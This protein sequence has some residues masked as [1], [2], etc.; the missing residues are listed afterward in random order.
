MRLKNHCRLLDFWV[1][2]ISNVFALS[3]LSLSPPLPGFPLSLPARCHLSLGRFLLISHTH[4]PHYIDIDSRCHSAEVSMVVN[5][6]ISF[7][8]ECFIQ[9]EKSLF[10]ILSLQTS[11][12][13]YIFTEKEEEAK[14]ESMKNEI[15]CV[16][17]ENA[18]ERRWT[19]GGEERYSKCVMC[20]AVTVWKK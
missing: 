12:I 8:Q 7:L 2:A 13:T 3:L 4:A 10:I 20:M 5:H 18:G 11:R 6:W 15:Q 14:N 17:T 19:R 1:R 9:S 16:N